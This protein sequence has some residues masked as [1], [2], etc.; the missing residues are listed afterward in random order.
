MLILERPHKDPYFNIAAE[1]L[2]LSRSIEDTFMIWRNAPSV[3]I[4]KHQI[5]NKEIDQEYVLRNRIPVIRRISGGGTVY[6]D[7]G[8]VNFTFILH[9]RG[10]NTID[11]LQFT[12]PIVNFLGTLGLNVKL[13]G[14]SNLAID[15]QKIS[16]NA[17]HV[18][19]D[20]VVYHGTLLFNAN[21][22]ALRNALKHDQSRYQDKAIA[23]IPANIVNLSDFLPGMKIEKFCDLMIDFIRVSHEA[24]K[25][26]TMDQDDILEINDLKNKKY[27]TWEWNYGYSPDYTFQN[28]FFMN[29]TEC[30]TA[31]EVKRG[32]IKNA[33]VYTG[34]DDEF[35]M[36]VET[37]LRG[38]PHDY[39]TVT[40]LLNDLSVKNDRNSDILNLFI[41]ELF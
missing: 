14:K 24:A 33:S 16:G 22:E 28:S 2:L 25:I 5:T 7:E 17:A 15:G 30:Y 31:F 32:L 18:F 3:I 29:S 21:L 6:H 4:G 9:G 10:R 20:K 35:D 19:K 27:C 11:F 40:G 13:S 36:K 8:N 41:K 39:G 34:W 37:R 38:Q 26:I 1:E 12:Q 23:S